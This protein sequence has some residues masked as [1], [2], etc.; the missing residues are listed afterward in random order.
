MLASA[1]KM[2]C[3]LCSIRL[4]NGGNFIAVENAEETVF[5]L[6]YPYIFT[7]L[8]DLCATIPPQCYLQNKPEYTEGNKA[9]VICSQC[10]NFKFVSALQFLLSTSYTFFASMF[11]Y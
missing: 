9:D 1:P 10:H 7:F 8:T 11:Q 5:C 2:F 3:S 4:A 6:P